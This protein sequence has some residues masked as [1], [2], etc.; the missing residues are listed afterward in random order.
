MQ[1][2]Q[3]PRHE[4]APTVADLATALTLV[5]PGGTI[6]V[7]DG[8]FVTQGVLV[9]RPVTIE[10]AA[11]S[12]PTLDASGALRILDIAAP[13]G[14]VM[15][16]GLRFV[17]ALN[18]AINT[19]TVDPTTPLSYDRLTL[20][21]V[22]MIIGDDGGVHE[23][24]GLNIV[25]S[26]TAG[27][28]ALVR[29]STFSGGQ[30]GVI[31]NGAGALLTV[32]NSNFGPHAFDGIQFQVGAIGRAE[33]NRLARCGEGGCIRASLVGNVSIVGNVM[34]FSRSLASDRAI[35]A[36]PLEGATVIVEG[37]QITDTRDTDDETGGTPYGVIG[38][39]DGSVEIRNNRID[40]LNG[41][42][43]VAGSSIKISGNDVRGKRTDHLEDGITVNTDPAVLHRIVVSSNS[44][45]GV[46]TPIDLM[47]P[48]AYTFADGGIEIDAV[49]V[50]GGPVIEQVAVVSGNTV[51]NALRGITAF[52]GA[53][54][55]GT[56]NVINVVFF[57]LASYTGSSNAVTRSDILS[58]RFAMDGD[59]I[60][61][62]PCNWWGD[63]AG[64]HDITSTGPTT[65]VPWATRPIAHGAHT[66][67]GR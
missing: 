32:L 35:H 19:E 11:R 30:L 39:G 53:S 38:S 50:S 17:G 10:A 27:A 28:F 3:T 8:T 58:Y 5:A 24:Y 62:V 51:H 33:G 42:R 36:R 60:L 4:D 1:N 55:R 56:D 52:A 43:V 47:D 26:S 41:V 40:G 18:S 45:V 63:V 23:N 6:R 61:V 57:G 31:A 34:A 37:N 7:F 16:R 9:D 2:A 59:G 65:F 46:D 25:P 64:P 21:H 49:P 12:H 13:H 15:L 22:S 14:E 67:C 66:A 48:S 44:I 20:D 29:Q 54:L